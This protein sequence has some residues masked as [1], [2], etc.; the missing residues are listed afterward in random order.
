MI[1][2]FTA[3]TEVRIFHSNLCTSNQ[4][5]TAESIF[6]NILIAVLPNIEAV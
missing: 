3:E 1:N 6:I 2:I 5:I 4:V